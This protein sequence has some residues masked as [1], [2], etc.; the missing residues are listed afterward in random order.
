MRRVDGELVLLLGGPRA[1]LLQLAH[2][3]V[4]RGVAEHSGFEADPLA[5]LQRT[6]DASMTIV[7]GTRDQARRAAKLVRSAHRRVHGDGYDA[8]DPD[9]LLWVH[10]TLVDTALRIH[11]RFLGGLT[12]E[13]QGEYYRQSMEVAALL[14]VPLERQPQDLDAFRAYVRSMVGSLAVGDEA[15]RLAGAVL[16]P[17]VPLPVEPAVAVVRNLTAGL[18]PPPIRRGYGL[19]WDPLREAALTAATIGLRATLP[20]VPPA[21]RRARLR[22]A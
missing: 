9:L 15:R 12:V 8:N 18:L 4:A 1:L 22:E 20:L 5:R 17:R 3:S 14:G 19:S 7:F 16:R 21:L 13:E 11:R 10:A 2:P 6:L